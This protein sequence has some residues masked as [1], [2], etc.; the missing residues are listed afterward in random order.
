M[1]LLFIC[2]ARNRFF[3]RAI[4]N[5]N[6]EAVRVILG[7]VNVLKWQ[8][9]NSAPSCAAASLK[10]NICAQSSSHIKNWSKQLSLCVMEYSTSRMSFLILFTESICTRKDS[11]GHYAHQKYSTFIAM[12]SSSVIHAA[13]LQSHV[14]LNSSRHQLQVIMTEDNVVR[15]Y[16]AI[17]VCG[18]FHLSRLWAS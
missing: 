4:E 12:L 10:C 7:T 5:V 6:R 18:T 14:Q 17:C 3:W 15:L 1:I 13:C 16:L 11:C 9:G 8:L 2:I